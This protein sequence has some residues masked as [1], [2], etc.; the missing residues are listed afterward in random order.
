MMNKK[1]F[2]SVF[3]VPAILVSLLLVHCGDSEN[4][5]DDKC[6]VIRPAKGTISSAVSCTGTVEPRNRLEILPTINGRVERILVREGQPVR[7]GQI[8]AWMSSEERAALIDA[9]RAQGKE[10]VKYWEATY[11]EIPI[12]SPISGTIIVR[13]IEPGQ[14]VTSTTAILVVSDRL[15]VKAT[16]DETD[17]GKIKNGQRARITLDA[18]P[19]VSESGTVSHISY[20]STT[21]NNVTTY[22][23]DIIPDRVPEVFRSGMTADLSIV[24]IEKKNILILPLS[25]VKQSDAGSSVVVVDE[26]TGRKTSKRIVTGLSDDSN[27]EIVSGL[28]EKDQVCMTGSTLTIP[29]NK[30]LDSPFLPKRRGKK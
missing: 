27:V 3:V 23:V 9:A 24:Q 20:E 28:G 19:E 4:N 14:S 11:K 13:D 17:I 16:V 21:V 29:Q 18:Y 22:E 2:L 30:S 6:T 8:L 10:S 5:T 1:I 26:K 7:A 15:I 12:L 25:A